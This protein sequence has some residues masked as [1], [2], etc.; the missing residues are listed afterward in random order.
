M[1]RDEVLAA[2][3]RGGDLGGEEL[4]GVGGEEGVRRDEFGDGAPRLALDVEALGHGLEDDVGPRYREGE[5]GGR[6]DPI[7]GLLPALIREVGEVLL[8]ALPDPGPAQGELV[9]GGREV[10]IGVDLFAVPGGLYDDLGSE[11]AGAE[12]SHCVEGE[13]WRHWRILS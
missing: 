13:F 11:D 6:V 4:G 5:V 8:V 1:H 9:E 10:V 12:D 2:P 7:E 3:G